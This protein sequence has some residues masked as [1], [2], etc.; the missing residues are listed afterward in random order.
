MLGL[1]ME[2]LGL[3]SW[4][5]SRWK[6][7][8]RLSTR[9]EAPDVNGETGAQDR[10]FDSFPDVRKVGAR[11]TVRKMGGKLEE[12]DRHRSRVKSTIPHLGK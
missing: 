7:G 5:D 12:Q 6:G 4:A 11:W 3:K 9:R 1:G 2:G 10:P 8:G